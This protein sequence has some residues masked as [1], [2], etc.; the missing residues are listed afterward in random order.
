ML[1]GEVYKG[2]PKTQLCQF[3]SF[4]FLKLCV[5]LVSPLHIFQVPCV[6]PCLP[7]TINGNRLNLSHNP[8]SWTESS[9]PHMSQ[10]FYGIV[11]CGLL[12]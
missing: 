10:R 6:N 2:E 12:F 4:F 7:L 9:S 8:V 1:L 5:N 11:I 3:K